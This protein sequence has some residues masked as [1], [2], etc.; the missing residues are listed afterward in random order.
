M[1]TVTG[2]LLLAAAIVAADDV[3]PARVEVGGGVIDVTI[4]PDEPSVSRPALLAWVE[5]SARAVS[6]YL[7][8]FPVP[9]LRLT[10]VTGGR[11]GAGGGT[12]WGGDEPRT[13][14]RA[15]RRTTEADL[16][17]DWVLTHEMV[18]LTFPDMPDGYAWMEEGLATYVEPIARARAGLLTEAEV[19]REL[20]DGLPEGQPGPHDGGLDGNR[21][22]GRTYW[23][24]A[25]Y[26][27]LA[28]VEI[29]ERTKN[30]KG[31]EDALRGILDAGGSIRQ[32]WPADRT[33]AAADRA[34]GGTT[35]HDLHARLGKKPER[36]DLD[37]L[38]K[39]LGVARTSGGV[40]FDDGA[41]LAAVR[42][43]ITA[44][45]RPAEAPARP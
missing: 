5:T 20:V 10:I 39:R 41:P 7:G 29:R 31:L 43:A 33:L 25:L 11:G 17:D 9:H 22:W 1:T 14:I 34:T 8:R 3:Q 44:P 4:G 36:V 24:G 35:L 21:S 16:A 15:G 38:W 13:R 27:L 42:R 2:G 23:G 28:D 18:H 6:G 40:T 19:W 30:R 37:A 45:Q 32:S 12:T 26:W